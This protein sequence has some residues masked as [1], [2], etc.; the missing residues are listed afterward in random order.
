MEKK[1]KKVFIAVL[2]LATAG[3]VQADLLAS[4]ENDGLTTDPTNLAADVTGTGVSSATLSR[5]ADATFSSFSDT[6]SW[7]DG[8]GWSGYETS[9][10][11]AVTAGAYIQASMNFS[12]SATITNIFWQLSAGDADDT[13]EAYFTLRSSVTGTT[14]IDT[15]IINPAVG[16]P[17]GF[18]FSTDLSGYA[19]LDGITT[20][21]FYL[22]HYNP[23]GTASGYA[24]RGV[25]D[26]FQTDG[27]NDL[28]VSGT[29]IPEPTTAGMLGLGTLVGLLV[30]RMRHRA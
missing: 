18:E 11:D 26:A 16:T 14:D 10:A 19:A 13:T 25:G 2:L 12:A 7:R 5:G 1:M 20:V 17:N 24:Q 6:F 15:Y 23:D 21:D 22:Y 28:V 9:L 29:V 30:R 3:L 8:N 27:E 4:W